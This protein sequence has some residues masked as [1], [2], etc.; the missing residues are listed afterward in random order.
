[1]IEVKNVRLDTAVLDKFAANLGMSTEQALFA[2][3]T[4]VTAY[5]V[6]KAPKKTRALANSIHPEKMGPLTVWVI[7][8]VEYGIYQELGTSK[9]WQHIPSWCLPLITQ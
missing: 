3:A 6:Q 1:M 2:T 4:Q 5:A 9:A 8:G 7:D